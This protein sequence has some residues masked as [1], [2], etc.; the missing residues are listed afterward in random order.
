MNRIKDSKEKTSTSHKGAVSRTLNAMLNGEFLTRAGV[1]QNLRFILFMTALFVV[2]ISIG[3]AFENTLR[4]HVKTKE[5]LEEATARY[6]A[7][8]SELENRKQASE[9][10]RQI[11]KLGLQEP[12]N[13]PQ[14][15]QPE[16]AV[17]E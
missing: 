14:V 3:Y 1:L 6:N 7:T 17:A 5:A 16:N 9:V 12:E 10:L 15:L 8:V 2:Y 11:D 4:A 13:Q